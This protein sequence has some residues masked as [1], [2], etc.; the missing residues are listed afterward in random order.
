MTEIKTVQGGIFTDYR[1]EISY[2]ND[3]DMREIRRFYMIRQSDPAIVRAWH[4]HRYEKKYFYA[5]KGS[6]TLAF[7][8]IDDW[9]HP[10]PELVAEIFR[11]SAQNSRILCIPEGYANA[12][13]ADE[14][15][16][17]L[18][19]YSNKI[20]SEAVHD[21]WRFDKDLWVDWRNY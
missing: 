15:D 12:V 4:G 18:M 20:L 8:K 19:V 9:K 3:F 16:S 5:V 21:S 1:G 7:V 14:A 11:V 13:K 6:F 2:V 10:S 17:V